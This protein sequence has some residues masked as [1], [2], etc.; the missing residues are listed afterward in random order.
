MS[1]RNV[2]DPVAI[3]GHYSRTKLH[4]TQPEIPSTLFITKSVTFTEPD[5]WLP[6]S[7][8]LNPVDYAII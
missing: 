1:G 7:P 2:L 5:E 4:L 8:D 3:T 6:K